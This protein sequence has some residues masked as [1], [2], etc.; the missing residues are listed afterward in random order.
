MVLASQGS[1]DASIAHTAVDTITTATT[2]A[3]IWRMDHPGVVVEV[4]DHS[5][6]VDVGVEVAADVVRVKMLRLQERGQR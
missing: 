2:R 1:S 5:E 6:A 3:A 4:V